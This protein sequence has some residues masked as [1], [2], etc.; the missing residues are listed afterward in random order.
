MSPAARGHSKSV[1]GPCGRGPCA[2][3]SLPGPWNRPHGRQGGLSKVWEQ[4]GDPADGGSGLLSTSLSKRC[5]GSR[6][7]EVL[8]RD[9]LALRRGTVAVWQFRRNR[10][11]V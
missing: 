6:A 10:I 9:L 1:E 11:V 7:P 8:W 5:R 2:S 3:F 4:R